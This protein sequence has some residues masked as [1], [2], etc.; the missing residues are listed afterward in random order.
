MLIGAPMRLLKPAPPP[1]AEGETIQHRMTPPSRDPKP[2]KLIGSTVL[3][4]A[5]MLAIIGTAFAA[6]PVMGVKYSGR[7]NGTATLTVSFKVSGSGKKIASLKV[8]PTLPN[9][10]G[11][12]GPLTTTETSKPAKIVKGKFSAKITEK[13]SSGAVSATAKVTGKFLANGKEKGSIKTS[14][15]NAKSCNGTFNYTTKAKGH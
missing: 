12:G 11:Y 15:P 14:L 4:V 1:V 2:S 10:C 7:V 6:A 5:A 8:S 9:S 13:T 3:V